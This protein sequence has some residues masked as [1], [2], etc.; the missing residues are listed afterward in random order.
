VLWT[1][2]TDLFER[3]SLPADRDALRALVDAPS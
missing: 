1:G 3:L 2:D